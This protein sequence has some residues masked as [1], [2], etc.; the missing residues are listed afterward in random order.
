MNYFIFNLKLIDNFFINKNI[1]VYIYLNC[2][3]KKLK[4][5]N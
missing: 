1:T 5:W 4:E 3:L 2:P